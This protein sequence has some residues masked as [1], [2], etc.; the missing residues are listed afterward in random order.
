MPTGQDYHRALV[1]RHP[2]WEELSPTVIKRRID[3]LL[4]APDNQ[5]SVQALSPVEY[6]ILLKESPETRPLLLALAHP[7]QIRTTLDLDCWDK[8]TLQSPQVLTW[9]EELQ[10]SGHDVFIRTLQALDIELLIA[11]FRKHMRI[12]ATLPIE[13]EEPGNYD[14]VSAN[15]LYRI[16]FI[17][18]ESPLNERILRLLSAL[19]TAD[20]NFYHGLLQSAMWG[21][22]DEAEEWAYRWKSG[23]LQDEG[24]PNYYEALETYRLI[25]LEQPLPTSTDSPQAPGIPVS[26]EASGLVPTYAWSLIPPGSLL[27]QA[28]TGDLSAATQERLCWEMVYLCNR[29]LVID[30]VDFANATE[31]RA[32]LSRVNAHLNIGLEHLSVEDA[33]RLTPLLTTHS[34]QSIC[35]V[36]FTLSMRLHQQALRLQTH[37]DHAAGVRRALPGLAR[38][39]LDGLLAKHPQFF[40]GLEY[41]G[42]TGYRN[43]LHVQDVALIAP[44]L[45]Y[46]ERDPAYHVMRAAS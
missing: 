36:G 31:V 33:Q 10:R 22:D 28:L 42:A 1:A 16:E 15:E 25:D 23:R 39:V 13:E 14:E 21:Q 11:T 44:V 8:D 24:F 32:S 27:A 19:R 6:I 2:F 30:Q 45:T 5:A 41:P 7:E 29:E 43:V 17:D 3:Q 20:L 12:H 38:Q 37:L 34:L 26:A 4:A 46:I 40:E 35:L 9:L 18:P